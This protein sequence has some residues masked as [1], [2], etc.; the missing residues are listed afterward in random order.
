LDGTP[1]MEAVAAIDGSFSPKP[2]AFMAN[3]T[4]ASIFRSALCHPL[5]SSARVME[6]MAG[7]FANTAALAPEALDNSDTLVEEDPQV[8]GRALAALHSD[9]GMKILGGCCGTDQRHIDR[10]AELLAAPGGGLA[11]LGSCH[12]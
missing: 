2:L 9:L 1:L 3:C 8:F 6:R 7:L 11:D 10:L 4:H 12:Q 5:H